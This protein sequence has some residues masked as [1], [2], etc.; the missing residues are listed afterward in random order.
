[1]DEGPEEER[2]S[3]HLNVV[4]L[5]LFLQHVD[6]RSNAKMSGRISSRA[7]YDITLATDVLSENVLLSL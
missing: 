3:F 2:I 7:D 5:N 4:E 1:M 6:V